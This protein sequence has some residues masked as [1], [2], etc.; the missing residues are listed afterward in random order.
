[1]DE[2]LKKKP[3]KGKQDKR[4]R[5]ASKPKLFS[6]PS[7]TVVRGSSDSSDGEGFPQ[8]NSCRSLSEPLPPSPKRA[9][10]LQSVEKS[11]RANK[12][13]TQPYL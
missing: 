8:G 7:N 4:I 5:P 9:K 3:E 10:P 12:P 13:E 2:M 6:I 11:L 1:M